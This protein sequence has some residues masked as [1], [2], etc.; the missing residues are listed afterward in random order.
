MEIP[1][2]IQEGGG[3]T[4]AGRRVARTAPQIPGRRLTT[5]TV[6]SK[7]SEELSFYTLPTVVG[8]SATQY[9]YDLARRIVQ[10]PG[11]NNMN[12]NLIAATLYWLSYT[13]DEIK[14][15]D[16]RLV[17]FIYRRNLIIP[18]NTDED[19]KIIMRARI[20]A[21]IIRYAQHIIEYQRLTRAEFPTTL[22]EQGLKIP[23]EKE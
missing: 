4:K 3:F 18:K 12:I 19:T 6:F 14:V 8:M 1:K 20:Q 11:I 17:E 22:E 13:G 15:I 9:R 5:Q 10:L 16:A 2:I 21:T 23:E 7:I